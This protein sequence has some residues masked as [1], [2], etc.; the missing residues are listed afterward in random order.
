MN[1]DIMADNPIRLPSGQGGLMRVDETQSKVQ[2]SP[3]IVIVM[4]ITIMLIILA[5]HYTGGKLF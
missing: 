3:G 4:A 1:E 2:F 5:L